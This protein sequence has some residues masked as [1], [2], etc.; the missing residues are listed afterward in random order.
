MTLTITGSRILIT[1]TATDAVRF[2]TDEGLFTVTDTINSSVVLPAL[3]ATSDAFFATVVNRD[4]TTTLQAVNSAA[5]HVFGAA[6]CIR[7]HSSDS[8]QK[9]A[10]PLGSAWRTVAGTICD[11]LWSTGVAGSFSPVPGPQYNSTFSGVALYTFELS[12]GNLVFNDRVIMR[13]YTPTSGTVTCTR[14]STTIEYR[15]YV[16]LFV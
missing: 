9:N 2:D 1:D 10:S 13:A 11:A 3:T 4:V 8:S 16:G 5:T 15:L 6:R 14:P 12:G 7:T